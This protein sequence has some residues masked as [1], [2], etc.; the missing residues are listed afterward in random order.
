MNKDV[1]DTLSQKF[2]VLEFTIALQLK[3]IKNNIAW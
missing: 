2:T 1:Y 3:N